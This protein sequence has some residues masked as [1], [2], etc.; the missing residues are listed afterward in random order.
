MAARLMYDIDQQRTVLRLGSIS[1]TPSPLTT[2][3]RLALAERQMEEAIARWVEADMAWR[4][5][6]LQ[7]RPISAVQDGAVRF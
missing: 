3:E 5:E 1:E 6:D 7:S 4:A 2:S